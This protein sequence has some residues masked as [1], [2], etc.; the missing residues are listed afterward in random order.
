MPA[1]R[2]RT[3]GWR[4]C[5]QQICDRRGSI[6]LAVRPPGEHEPTPLRGDLLFRA[7]VIALDRDSIRVETPV[8]LGM[9]VEFVKG[10]ELVAIMAIGQNRWMFH[11][12][13]MGA[14]GT[15]RKGTPPALRLS[16]PRE[17]QRC[18][19][20]RDY[21]IDTADLQLPDVQMW[22]LLDPATVVPAERLAAVDFQ[23]EL[24]G[25]LVAGGPPPLDDDL[26]PQL[27]PEHGG[28][29][30]NLGG[31]GLGLAVGVEDAGVIGRHATW[32]LRFELPPSV[33]TPIYAAAR[34]AHRHLR[35]DRSLYCGMCFDFSANPSHHDVVARQIMRAI[36]GLQRRQM[37]LRK[38]G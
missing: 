11:T 15:G 33:Q 25:Q 17:V 13:C 16:A 12:M 3:A 21:R 6:E 9:A 28:R 24:D 18:Q 7:R 10:L 14:I 29:I 32:W 27:G 8:S 22:P 35:S 34:V 38:A 1:Q 31:G 4:H 23:R 20:R 37:G 26:L 30:V 19:R 2:S 5:L 36:A